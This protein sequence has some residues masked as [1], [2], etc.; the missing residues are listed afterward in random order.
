[1]KK[2][3]MAPGKDVTSNITKQALGNLNPSNIQLSGNQRAN[4]DVVQKKG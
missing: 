2:K 1:M 3:V 4:I